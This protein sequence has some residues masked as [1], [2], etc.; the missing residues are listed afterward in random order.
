MNTIEN[1]RVTIFQQDF[2]IQSNTYVGRIEKDSNDKEYYAVIYKEDSMEKIC[3]EI[4][5]GV[6]NSE[7]S[8]IS[9]LEELVN[10]ANDPS[11]YG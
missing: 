4:F 5:M 9:E 3:E 2:G 10:A 8:Y 1:T 6:L 11:Y 7:Q